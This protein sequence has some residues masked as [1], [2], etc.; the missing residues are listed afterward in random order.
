MRSD[1]KISEY[2]GEW[3][4]GDQFE[5]G[6]VITWINPKNGHRNNPQFT[7]A[8]QSPGGSLST[9]VAIPYYPFETKII[10]SK[11]KPKDKPRKTFL[12]FLKSLFWGNP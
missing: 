11:D 5:D 9:H 7:W 6:S 4:V 8:Q 12:M 3:R 2:P 1:G 10:P